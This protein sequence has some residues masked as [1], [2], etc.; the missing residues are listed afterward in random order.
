MRVAGEQPSPS[1]RPEKVRAADCR[2]AGGASNANIVRAPLSLATRS[3]PPPR[4]PALLPPPD[5]IY[6]LRLAERPLVLHWNWTPSPPPAGSAAEARCSSVVDGGVHMH[7]IPPSGRS[8][9][10]TL[11]S[12]AAKFLPCCKLRCYFI[13]G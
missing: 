11:R 9:D 3:S 6:P 8:E 10:K 1:A 4:D 7:S 13:I 5:F 2:A 12:E